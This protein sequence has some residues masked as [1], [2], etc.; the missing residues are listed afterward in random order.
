MRMFIADCS[1]RT[2]YSLKPS[3]YFNTKLEQDNV[4]FVQISLAHKIQTLKYLILDPSTNSC[5]THFAVKAY[6]VVHFCNLNSH[7]PKQLIQKVL[8]FLLFLS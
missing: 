8:K 4:T 1:L 2:L 6:Q 5:K 3:A 7:I